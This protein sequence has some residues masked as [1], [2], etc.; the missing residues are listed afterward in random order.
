MIVFLW[1]KVLTLFCQGMVEEAQA[2]LDLLHMVED[3]S[4][5]EIECLKLE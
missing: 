5:E 3:M 1:N 2:Q 4:E